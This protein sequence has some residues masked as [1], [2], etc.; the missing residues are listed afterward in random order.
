MK[1][2]S[3]NPDAAS[4]EINGKRYDIHISSVDVLDYGIQAAQFAREID[5]TEDLRNYIAWISERVDEAL[6]A[7]TMY[8]IFGD[9]PI[10]AGPAL[11]VLNAI[12]AAA[13]QAH[14][15]YIKKEYGV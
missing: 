15:Q 11:S 8:D 12:I 6:G 7:G 2:I 13:S 4:V 9:T 14:K 5:T 3:V 10:S 1:K